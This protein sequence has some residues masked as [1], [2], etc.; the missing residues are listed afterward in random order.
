M[1]NFEL[2]IKYLSNDTA[3][4]RNL[5]LLFS[6]IWGI[7]I[8]LI[9][10]WVFA[11][12]LFGNAF[13]GILIVAALLVFTMTCFFATMLLMD[14]RITLS[15]NGIRFPPILT[16]LSAYTN[17]AA[18]SKIKQLQVSSPLQPNG[19]SVANTPLSELHLRFEMVDA[20]EISLVVEA[21]SSNDLEKLLMAL[22]VWLPEEKRDA[23]LLLLKQR[24]DGT[25]IAAGDP[26]SYTKIWQD[27]LDSRFSA[28]AFM[29]LEPGHAFANRSLVVVRQLAFGGLSAVYFC[30]E[31]GV[32]N[33]ILKESVVPTNTKQELKLKAKEMFER[34]AAILLQLN[35]EQIVKVIQFFSEDDRTYILLEYVD[36]KTLRQ[37]VGEQGCQPEDRVIRIAQSLCRPLSYLHDR[38][39]SIIHK[40]ISPE[41]IVVQDDQAIIIDFGAANEFLGTVTST[42]VGKQAY[43]APEQFAGR[44]SASSDLYS[45]GATLYFLLTGTD[46]VP[47]TCSSP[48]EFFCVD[49]TS[50]QMVV[51]NEMD[52]FVKDLTELERSDRLMSVNAVLE[53]LEAMTQSK[54]QSSS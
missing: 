44:A 39:P 53:R 6:P 15:K 49:S 13:A 43:V 31:G 22:S 12:Y 7:A 40:D 8:P 23:N 42:M 37:I 16:I 46:P 32:N 51:S 24:L 30:Q 52:Q 28:T 45:L 9:G 20:D 38:N 19:A 27:E 21:I 18:W 11:A 50:S 48:K 3:Y 36:G 41:N 4:W 2:T 26:P 35:H 25:A 14:T 17:E 47:L 5:M 29:P 33:R 34:E 54:R 1:A 10:L